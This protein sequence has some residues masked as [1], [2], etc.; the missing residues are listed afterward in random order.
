MLPDIVQA[1]FNEGFLFQMGSPSMLA[2]GVMPPA[3]WKPVRRFAPLS[4]RHIAVSMRDAWYFQMTAQCLGPAP[5]L[6]IGNSHGVSTLLLATFLSPG[7][8]DAIDAET[9]RNSDAGSELTRRVAERLGLDVRVTHGFSPQDLDA[10]CRSERYGYVLI[11]GDHTNE[12]IVL[13][14]EGIKDRLADRCVVYLHDVGLRDME[15]GWLRV[16]ELAEPLGLRGFDLSATDFGSTLLVR[17]LPKLERTLELTCPGLRAH[18]DIYHNGL[19]MP[20]PPQRPDTDTL[21][22][23]GKSRVAFYGAGND[24]ADYGHFIMSHR[25]R[26]EAIYDDDPAAIG[27]VRYGVTV[28][29]GSNLAQ[30]TADAIVISTHGH[31]DSVRGRIAEHRSLTDVYPRKGLL[32]PTCIVCEPS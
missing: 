16:R 1:Y 15:E 14:F 21:V 5:C 7:P 19:A 32:T 2:S 11:D 8:T 17:G 28:K 23:R 26:V 31:A 12:Q 9:S 30:S 29:P 6:V 20:I 18:N 24:L 13:D 22:L 10:A 4:H 25:D 27:T 3:E